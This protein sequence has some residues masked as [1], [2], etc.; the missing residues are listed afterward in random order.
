VLR[1]ST[2]VVDVRGA[3]R[4][5]ERDKKCLQSFGG[6]T[7]MEV[8]TMKTEVDGKIILKYIFKEWIWRMSAEFIQRRLL[9][10]ENE[11]SRFEHF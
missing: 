3:C 8:T 5:S 10:N 2:L 7:C 9:R 4:N 11:T 6:E 1:N